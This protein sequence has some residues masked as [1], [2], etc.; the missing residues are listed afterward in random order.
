MSDIMLSTL[1]ALYHLILIITLQDKHYDC[2]H[3]IE[4]ESLCHFS[5]EIELLSNR[6]RIPTWFQMTPS[7]TP[8]STPWHPFG[9]QLC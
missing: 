4:A 8:Y 6:T 3:F 2:F 9:K 5:G 7:L 1:H